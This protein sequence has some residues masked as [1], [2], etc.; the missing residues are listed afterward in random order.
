MNLLQSAR[1]LFGGAVNPSPLGRL[2]DGE[3]EVR[4]VGATDFT[5]GY[6]ASPLAVRVRAERGR[7][8]YFVNLG[9]AGEITA[10]RGDRQT[11][12]SSTR[13][14]VFNPGDAQDLRPNQAGTRFLG[15]RIDAGLVR[16]ELAALTGR[17]S[18]HAVRF[19][20]PLDLAEPRG[21]AV[22]LL[23]GSLIEQLDSNDPL[24]Q[25]EELR[26]S[27]L[28][29]IVTALL[30]AQNHTHTAT[31]RGVADK[32]HP[33]A[34]RAAV[35]FIEDNLREPI[36]LGRI[37]EAA[38]CGART[39]SNAFRDKLG[40]S[41]MKYVRDLRLDRIRHDILSTGDG[42]GD[43]ACRWGITHLG[44]FANDYRARFGE[45]PS[46]TAARR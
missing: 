8:S 20:F 5:V 41:P 17:P 40:T 30:L 29:C 44:R 25:R 34:L 16:R 46:A 10:R 2:Q 3:H 7:D 38:G 31:L 42:I 24:F 28:R 35:A 26:R 11:V 19:D 6:F 1:R 15:L 23:I 4:G 33:R 13:A 37:A 21:S 18:G 22:R 45:L 36:S 12:L 43:I 32:P 27:Q 14:G 9:V 39:V